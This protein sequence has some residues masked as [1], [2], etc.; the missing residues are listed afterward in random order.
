[1]RSLPLYIFNWAIHFFDPTENNV[2]TKNHEV[3]ILNGRSLAF[4]PATLPTVHTY[5]E[6]HFYQTI[7]EN[8][9]SDPDYLTLNMR[10]LNI[11]V[12]NSR[13]LFNLFITNDVWDHQYL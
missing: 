12:T 3:W 6:H 2:L 8:E 5:I 10:P 9:Y 4:E 7:I 11:Q 13:I 1:M